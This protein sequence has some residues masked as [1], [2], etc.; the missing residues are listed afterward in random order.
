MNVGGP[1]PLSGVR[2]LGCQVRSFPS[3][4]TRGVSGPVPKREAGPGPL[5]R[6]G[7][8]LTMGPGCSALYRVV[9]DNYVGLA[10]LQ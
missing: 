5:A 3:S 2:G 10:L 9:T 7:K 6:G 1:G 8:D 4:G